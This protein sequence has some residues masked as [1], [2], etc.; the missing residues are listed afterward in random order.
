MINF[1]L[2]KCYDNKLF[3]N[4]LS[5]YIHDFPEHLNFNEHI[6]IFAQSGNTS[7]SFWHGGIN[8]NWNN[9]VVL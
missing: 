6:N 3:N 2:P 8:T 4:I 9:K 5:N 7:F 1:I